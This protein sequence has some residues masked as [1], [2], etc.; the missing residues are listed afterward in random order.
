MRDASLRILIYDENHIRASILE[1]GLREAGL[2]QI[3]VVTELNGIVARIAE[4]DPQVI[5]LDLANPNRDRLESM[6]QVSRTISRPIAVFV[7]EADSDTIDAAVDAGVSA[8]IV[9]GL[10]KERVTSILDI[11]ISR[12]NAFNRL[13][14]ELDEVR[15]ELADR[16]TID[17]A[18]LLL[19]KRRD[20]N[21]NEAYA[22]LRR[23][24]MS[25]SCRIVEVAQ[26]LVMTADL[27]SEDGE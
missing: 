15:T 8:Y 11:T 1:E 27:L 22:L 17:Q 6:L 3:A 21:E 24:A 23:T 12:F 4:F 20:I 7:D 14:S 13:K 19:M 18:K 5:F 16:K 10:K 25:R 2:E 26:S 9:D